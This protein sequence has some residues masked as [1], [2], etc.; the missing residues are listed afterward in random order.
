M[1]AKLS[2]A[3]KCFSFDS[4]PELENRSLQSAT[5]KNDRVAVSELAVTYVHTYLD[6]VSTSTPSKA[7]S[8]FLNSA[9]FLEVKCFSDA[10][11]KGNTHTH[12]HT[13]THVCPWFSA[14]THNTWPDSTE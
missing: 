6:T 13:H 5:A 8:S 11:E 9:F 14:R 1:N 4:K 3:R 2:T 7:M 10:G 12:T